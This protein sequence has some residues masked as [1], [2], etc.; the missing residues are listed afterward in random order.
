MNLFAADPDWGVWIILYFFLGGIGAGAYFVAVLVEWFGS[1]EDARSVRVA[2]LIAFPLTAACLLLLVIDLGR[3]GRFWHML[4]RSEVV[5]LA[6]AEGFP[7]SA[8]GWRWALH[9]PLLKPWSPMSAGSWGLG[10]FAFASFV[11]FLGA[12]RPGWRVSR[13][14]ERRWVRQPVRVIGLLS[15]F[16]V[17]SYT[18]TL[19]SA[20]NQPVWSD[21]TWLSPLFFASSLSTGLAAVLLLARRTDAGTPEARHKLAAADLWAVGLE[22]MVFLAFLAS[23]GWLVEPVLRTVTGNVLIFGTLLFGLVA[24]VVIHTVYGP[25]RWS[26]AAAAACV[27]AG[28]LCL[29]AGA[30]RVNA[31]LLARGP[32]VLHGV[33]P[34]QTRHVG[35]PGAD[36]GNHGPDIPARTKLPGEP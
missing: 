13:W 24:P 33:S 21:T 20:S 4:F 12:W 22:A 16:Y 14:L 6:F 7:F 31:E 30:V 18:G 23:L 28:G 5:K 36:P 26:A 34:E 1:G 19:M 15:A 2:H 32:A 35:Q 3:P 11:S 8:A 17:G 9:A 25:R 29:R 10:V 27:L